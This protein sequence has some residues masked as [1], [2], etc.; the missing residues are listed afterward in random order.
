MADIAAIFHWPPSEMYQMT[1][2]EIMEWRHR[3]WV[4]SGE[5]DE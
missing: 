3:A 5:S 2:A 4:R 1:V